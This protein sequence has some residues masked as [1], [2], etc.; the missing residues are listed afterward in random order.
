MCGILVAFNPKGIDKNRVIEF[1]DCLNTLKHRGPDNIGFFED[2]NILIGHTR[3]SIIDVEIFANQP[4]FDGE[5]VLSYNGEIFNYQ[6]IK[7]DLIALGFSFLTNSDTEVFLKAYIAW[8]NMCFNKFN[9]MWSSVI[10]NRFDKSIVVSRD[11]FGQKPL[12]ISLHNGTF[13]F[14]SEPRQIYTLVDPK[15]NYSS[16]L[17]FLREGDFNSEGET[18]FQNINEFPAANFLEVNCLSEIKQEIFWR[19][20]EKGNFKT[21]K[22]SFIDFE[23]LLKDSVRIRLRSDVPFAVCLSGGVDSTVLTDIIRELVGVNSSISTYTYSSGDSV[24]ESLFAAKVANILKCNNT[25]TERV[26][27]PILFSTHLSK[28]VIHMGRGH[29]SPAIIPYNLI[30]ENMRMDG[31]K[32]SLDGQ[33][34]DELL[35]GYP[36]TFISSMIEN[37]FKLKFR[38]FYSSFHGLLNSSNEYKL[39]FLYL[40][41]HYFR[42]KSPP[43]IRKLMRSV[44]GYEALFNDNLPCPKTGLSLNYDHNFNNTFSLNSHL[45]EQHSKSLRNLVFYGD[46]VSMNN[47]VENRS[48]FLDHRLVEF[49]FQHDGDLKIFKGSNKY[50]IKKLDSYQR[51][52]DILE[53]KKVGFEGGIKIEIKEHMRDELINSSIL[54]WDIFSP[55]LKLFLLSRRSISTKYERFLFRLFQVHLWALEY[56]K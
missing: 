48:P 15:P 9:G 10:Y 16:I 31:F 49:V 12:F 56:Y 39:G 21:T 14:S 20:P 29:S 41:I 19:Y 46:I 7:Q 23:S 4:F 44:Y 47:S 8:G 32:V 42:A 53:R 38:N 30:Q 22:R 28:L 18:F 40:F 33:G 51:F 11:R 43:F 36:L 55:K 26:V 13:Y 5:Y 54:E 34:A 1:K 35:A 25:I 24:D 45:I 3:L 2:D 17:S 6:E 37:I 52:K 50:A 27:D